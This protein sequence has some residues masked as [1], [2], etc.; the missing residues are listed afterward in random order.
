MKAAANGS[1]NLQSQKVDA[2][3]I[4][5]DTSY[6]STYEIMEF[7]GRL[8][9]VPSLKPVRRHGE[10]TELIPCRNE[11]EELRRLKQAVR[12]FN[13]GKNA[14]L[15]IIMKTESAAR[16]LHGIL[17]REFK[18]NLITKDSSA[19]EE[20]VSVTSVRMSK[21]LEFDEAIVLI[22]KFAYDK[23][24]SGYGIEALLREDL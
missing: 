12:D 15:G 17:C 11:E 6:R 23:I 14:T 2:E 21:G 24:T 18:V 3:F 4:R 5:L 22:K 16:E 20:G 1:W 13:E 7:A 10:K 8:G 9:H 19:F